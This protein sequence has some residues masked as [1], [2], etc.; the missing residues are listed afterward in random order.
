[1]SVASPRPLLIVTGT[2]REA[3]VL[4]GPD[5]ITLA[6]GGD[7]DRLAR[8]ID[9]RAGEVCGILSFGM[10]GALDPA[11]HLGD[12]VIGTQVGDAPCDPVFAGAMASRLRSGRRLPAQGPIHASDH[13][14]AS[15]WEK[16]DLHAQTGAIACDMESHVVAAAATRHG[17]R[18]AVLR[19]ISDAADTDLPP[20]IAVAMKPGGG[21]ALGRILWSLL[22]H[23]LQVPS[24]IATTRRFGAAFKVLAGSGNRALRSVWD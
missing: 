15:A 12:W 5:V 8:A 19:C 3:K 9:A 21:L 22:R 1:M 2:R 11:L 17:L 18:F 20:A 6:G 24:L 16:S 10:A 23:P 13:L 7:S 14:I 4:A